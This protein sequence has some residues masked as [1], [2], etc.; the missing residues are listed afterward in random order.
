MEKRSV[1]L[2]CKEGR[3][4][5]LATAGNHS[6]HQRAF[7]DVGVYLKSSKEPRGVIKKMRSTG[8]VFTKEFLWLLWRTD[9][10]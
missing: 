6:G 3:E 4:A 10:R 9:W 1:S 8:A 7:K 2:A 5:G